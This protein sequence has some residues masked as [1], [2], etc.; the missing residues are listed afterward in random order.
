M[1]KIGI[2]VRILLFTFLGTKHP[3][4]VNM[5]QS[6]MEQSKNIFFGWV[7]R[8]PPTFQLWLPFNMEH[9]QEE[10]QDPQEFHAKLSFHPTPGPQESQSIFFNMDHLQGLTQ[11]P[12]RNSMLNHRV[13]PPGNH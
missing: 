4:N 9:P 13:V 8:I 10:R 11:D 6:N 5:E 1:E 12:P 2:I 7:A 3:R